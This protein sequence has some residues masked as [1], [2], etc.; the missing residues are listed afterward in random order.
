MLRDW[1][2]HYLTDPKTGTPTGFVIDIM[3]E[4]ADISGLE[5]QYAVYNDWPD[6]VAALY[7]R[8]I[9]PILNCSGYII[10]R[11]KAYR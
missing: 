6:A 11:I 3:D 7:A 2:P 10:V 9:V 1:Q 4:I 5:F 8:G